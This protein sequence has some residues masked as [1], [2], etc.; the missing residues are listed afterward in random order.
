VSTT[1]ERTAAPD[2]ASLATPGPP[3][4]RP[5]VAAVLGL[6]AAALAV[7]FPFMPV[8]QDTAELRWPTA[9]GGTA[10]VNAPLVALRPLRFTAEVGCAALRGLDARSAGPAVVLATTPPGSPDG[11][12]IGLTVTVD[13]GTLTVSDRGSELAAAVLA[14][15]DCDLSMSSTAT[16]TE[17][18]LGG[19][20]L[21]S[22]AGDQRPQVVGVYS[23]LDGGL[24]DMTGT[25]VRI[26]VDNRFDSTASVWKVLVGAAA[27]LALL[28][29]LFALRYLDA[30]HG[31]RPV[32]IRPD[33]GR[34]VVRDAAV[35]AALVVWAAVGSMTADDGYILTM[36]RSAATS[37]WVGNFFRWFD[38][39]EAPFGWFYELYAL[40]A[41]ISDAV[42]WLRIPA[43]VL[44]ILSWWL[45]SRQ[46]L[47]R[48]GVAAGR[49][50]G[51]GW[52]AAGL[53]LSFW[54]PFGNGLRP[55]PVVVIGALLSGCAV[56]RALATRRLTPLALGLVAAAFAVAATPTGLLAAAPILAGARPLLKLLR[57]RSAA[58]G[59][60]ATLGPLAGAGMIVLVAVFADQTWASVAEAVRV[61]TAIG[62][63]LPWFEELYR[64]TLLFTPSRDG[65]MARR[66]AVLVLVVCAATAAVVLLRRGRIPGAATG[67]ARRL[68]GTIVIGF[69]VL[70]LTPT[71][72]THHFGAFAALAAAAAALAAI[73]TGP[74]V[75]RSHQNRL[76]VG[77]A[78]LAVTSLA[79]TGPNTWWYVSNW[80]VPWFDRPPVIG[81]V[82][83][84]TVFLAG[85]ALLLALAAVEYLRGPAP[86][87]GTDRTGLVRAVFA[88]GAPLAVL[89]GLIVLFEIASLAKAVQKQSDS[90]SLG[91]DVLS[92]PTGADCGLSARVLVET[93]P[94]AGGLVPAEGSPPELDGFA[95]GALPRNGPGSADDVDGAGNSDPTVT[96][97]GPVGPV[98]SSY[99]RDAGAT[100]DLQTSW[101]T[102][103][104]ST[105]RGEVPLVLGVAGQVGDGT[106]VGI[107]LGR[108]TPQGVEVVDRLGV[109]AGAPISAAAD[110]FGA[111]VGGRGWRDVRFDLGDRP[112]AAGADRVRVVAEDRALLPEGWVAV[113]PPRVPR[114]TPMLDLIGDQPG[115][116]DWPVPLPHPC[117]RQFEI[118]DGIAEMPRYR[119][120]ADPQQRA[121]GDMWSAPPSGGPLA[122]ITVVAEQRVLPTYLEGDWG[123]DWGQL[124]LIT[125]Y[126]PTAASPEVRTG[127]ETRWGW[128][129]AGPIG[130][131]PAGRPTQF[132]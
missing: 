7:A 50:R 66:F 71:K 31:R 51:A 47:P 9:A 62:P 57:V 11:P 96:A 116:L 100:G 125:P 41:Q 104:G 103:P 12:A 26:E 43:L 79:F 88:S 90:Y 36:A 34:D 97:P 59:A 117:L 98:L 44:G 108:S 5:V 52:A 109:G 10:A 89:C 83:F 73:A 126:A 19:A 106:S 70:A 67:P 122:W 60:L 69:G 25:A 121:V 115:F 8:H 33:R 1:E 128:T 76:L 81:G 48:L 58:A 39:P 105:L 16:R 113:T 61:R 77:A 85:T 118:S 87:T 28:G 17:V 65:S 124:R 95:P 112:E 27:V 82:D 37:G 20:A 2:R 63:N 132:R 86:Q 107:E 23:D 4:L 38:V 110:P 49:S 21:V 72:W 131:P 114:L 32:R 92:D 130:E 127:N 14:G 3:P 13:D 120:L 54:L 24:D 91:G 119:M 42:L 46:M 56:E 93:D 99:R 102:L 80:G 45:I 84:S 75:L 64:Y 111:A 68:I 35:V 22:A 15:P 6:L 18:R 53:F 101:Y 55:E 129:E 40:W 74:A 123:R 30:A 78:L 29:S 94:A